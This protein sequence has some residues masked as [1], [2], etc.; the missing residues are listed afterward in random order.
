MTFATAALLGMVNTQLVAAEESPAPPPPTLEAVQAVQIQRIE[1]GNLARDLRRNSVR[2]AALSMG[3][4][5]GLARRM[6]EIRLITDREISKLDAIW[7]F[8]PLMVGDNVVPPVLAEAR[9][10]FKQDGGEIIRTADRSYRILA[11][12]HFSST[13]PHWR[14]YLIR[15]FTV[16]LDPPHPSLLPKDEAEKTLWEQSVAEGW[17]EGRN[18]ADQIF[19]RDLNRLKRDYEGMILYRVLLRS[20]MVSLP[21]VAKSTLGVTGD[22][23][24]LHIND[25]VLRITALPEFNREPSE[26]KPQPRP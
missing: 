4:R 21:Y 1:P 6:Y 16:S 26:W 24:T 3:A 12:A 23:E 18:Q 14:E 19:E 2:D 22:R 7:N 5:A 25:S 10:P 20:N 8:R 15:D 13:P 11:Q 17:K 9:D